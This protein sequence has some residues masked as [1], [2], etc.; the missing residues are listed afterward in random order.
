M[1]SAQALICTRLEESLMRIIWICLLVAASFLAGLFLSDVI[2]RRARAGDCD[3]VPGGADL[4]TAQL[5]R[6]QMTSLRW[7]HQC[8]EMPFPATAA[9]IAQQAANFAKES[10]QIASF[11]Q[12]SAKS[13]ALCLKRAR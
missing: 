9:A 6:K 1:K 3:A 8:V 7:E 5:V 12:I 4:T 13:A 10:W 2:V 11:G